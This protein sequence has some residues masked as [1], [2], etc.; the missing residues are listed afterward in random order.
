MSFDSQVD[1]STSSGLLAQYLTGGSQHNGTHWDQWY[2]RFT[3][4]HPNGCLSVDKLDA[5][6]YGDQDYGDPVTF[7]LR[8]VIGVAAGL[9]FFRWQLVSR[10]HWPTKRLVPDLQNKGPHRAK[11][12]CLLFNC[13]P[14]NP[15]FGFRISIPLMPTKPYEFIDTGMWQSFV[16]TWPYSPRFDE[17]LLTQC[18]RDTVSILILA[19]QLLFFIV[20]GTAAASWADVTKQGWGF[21]AVVAV[22]N[23]YIVSAIC[24]VSKLIFIAAFGWSVNS[25]G[26]A[27]LAMAAVSS[28]LLGLLVIGTTTALTN[29]T[30]SEFAVNIIMPF[31]LKQ[32]MALVAAPIL[33]AF[34]NSFG[35]GPGVKGL[36]KIWDEIDEL[37]AHE[38]VERLTYLGRAADLHVADDEGKVLWWLND[39]LEDVEAADD[40]L[41]E[42]LRRALKETT[43]VVEASLL[44]VGAGLD[45]M[46]KKTGQW[47]VDRDALV[48]KLKGAHVVDVVKRHPIRNWRVSD[49]DMLER[50]L[51]ETAGSKQPQEAEMADSPR[52]T[53]EDE[54]ST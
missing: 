8:L 33:Y 3:Q 2:V 46:H 41:L 20:L 6:T 19:M 48:K 42:S 47:K 11:V 22:C 32:P 28:S 15:H 7:A 39:V 36:L 51:S 9:A 40:V 34:K 43:Y 21:G 44:H 18:A 24:A 14:A 29:L 37:S 52:A 1:G 53:E 13:M 45:K 17:P 31:L 35:S 23:V 12:Q 4:R 27:V 10:N 16:F 54:V 26:C 25:G 30:C 50:V 49:I 38:C 5:T